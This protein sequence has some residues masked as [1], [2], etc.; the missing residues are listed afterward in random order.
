[1]SLGTGRL[2]ANFDV[3][4]LCAAGA[5]LVSHAVLVTTGGTW[6]AAHA[7]GPFVQIGN[8]AVAV[9]FV[10][11][12]ILVTQSWRGDPAMRRYLARRALRLLPALLVT[13]AVSALVVGSIVSHLTP[14]TYL[15]TPGTWAYL[16]N[17]TAFLQPYQL[18]GVFTHLPDT[19]TVNGSLWT[20]RYEFL[21]YLIV[22][23]L[24]GLVT[25]T[26]RRGVLLA[27]TAATT[28]VATATLTTHTGPFRDG[29]PWSFAGLPGAIG[30]DV[31][32]LFMLMSYF[33]AGMCIQIWLPKLRFD[34]RLAALAVPL[35]IV[36]SQHPRLFPLSV[37]ALAYAVAY[38]GIAARPVARRLV[39]LGDASYGMYVWGFVVE[40]LVVVAFGPQ[41]SAIVVVAIAMPVTWTIGILSWRLIE[42]PALR[43]KPR[44]PMSDGADRR[45]VAV[46]VA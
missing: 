31:V 9:F 41:I 17:G 37:A 45:R 30:W 40:Q 23:L 35:F 4:R 26:R 20:L 8:A 5:V 46:E 36:V 12:G 22:P 15:R 39:A 1:M 43:F 44:A 42:K 13:V 21:C 19:G 18:P 6:W 34:G 32:P 28:L 24:V 38:F 25:V 33:L 14:V 2:N 3:L 10:I 16:L 11:S 7:T 27:I 29:I